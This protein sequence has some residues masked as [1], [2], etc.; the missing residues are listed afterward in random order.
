LSNLDA[1]RLR[2]LTSVHKSEQVASFGTLPEIKMRPF[3][4]RMPKLISIDT[5]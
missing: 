1:K 3:L 2:K 4:P 5:G